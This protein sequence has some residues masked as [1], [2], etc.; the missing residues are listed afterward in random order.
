VHYRAVRV[1]QLVGGRMQLASTN[2]LADPLLHRQREARLAPVEHRVRQWLTRRLCKSPLAAGS[3]A[4]QRGTERLGERAVDEWNA[5]REAVFNRCPISISQKLI[6]HV[7]ALLSDRYLLNGVEVNVLKRPLN[8][9][10][11]PGHA[12]AGFPDVRMHQLPDLLRREEPANQLERAGG[13]RQSAAQSLQFAFAPAGQKS[14]DEIRSLGES[15][16]PTGESQSP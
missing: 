10:H 12:V 9:R 3:G 5:P 7:G 16:N 1:K 11:D 6:A 8:R 2:V 4:R 14:A 15:R 13:R